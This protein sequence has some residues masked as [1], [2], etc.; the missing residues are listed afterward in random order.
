MRWILSLTAS[1]CLASTVSSGAVGGA[2][3]PDKF[4]PTCT[5][6]FDNIKVHRPLDATCAIEGTPKPEDGALEANK[7]QNRAKNNFC[8]G[9]PAV[10]VTKT[11]FKNLETKTEAL[12][13]ATAGSAHP[14]TFGSHALVPEDRAAIRAN[15]FNVTS[16]G[17]Q[18]HEGTLVRAV[19]Y[20][21]Q[22][23]YSSTSGEAVNCNL[24]HI[25]NSD[26][27]LVLAA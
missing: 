22:A 12:E 2:Q 26:I 24:G 10:T 7:E 9:G 6:P 1:A 4:T 5:L 8:A 20:L 23:K 17:D 11:T 18:V 21:M 14:F 3:A 16:D 27:H 13:Q 19:A 25:G 15:G